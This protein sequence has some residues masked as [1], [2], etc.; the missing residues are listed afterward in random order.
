MRQIGAACRPT[1][2]ERLR[3][4]ID[5]LELEAERW[6][7]EAQRLGEM[8]DIPNFLRRAAQ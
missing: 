2:I 4:V 7:K 5:E 8:P 3:E 1:F 6:A